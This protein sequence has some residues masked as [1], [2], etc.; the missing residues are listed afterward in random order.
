MAHPH[1]TDTN[2]G[3]WAAGCRARALAWS[4]RQK[5][6][7]RRGRSRSTAAS[8]AWS[9]DCRPEAAAARGSA[10]VWRWSWAPAA[11]LFS[12][13]RPRA[14]TVRAVLR[15]IAQ[16]RQAGHNQQC[17]QQ[18]HA[19]ADDQQHLGRLRQTEAGLVAAPAEQPT[20]HEQRKGAGEYRATEARAQQPGAQRHVGGELGR[21]CR[22][23]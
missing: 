3:V 16:H 2:C 6:L 14:L 13:H 5:G 20:Q 23:G 17:R 10:A 4:S 22:L 7:L 1:R 18:P 9:S 19:Q 15:P 12:H 11:L 21:Q 8:A